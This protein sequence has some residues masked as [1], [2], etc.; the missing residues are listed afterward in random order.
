MKLTTECGVCEK[1]I[2]LDYDE[3]TSEPEYCPFCGEELTDIDGDY[4]VNDE[5]SYDDLI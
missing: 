1:R 4:E 2:K 3:S 5:T